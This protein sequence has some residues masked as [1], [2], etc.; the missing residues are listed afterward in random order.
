MP[1]QGGQTVEYDYRAIKH[2]VNDLHHWDAR[3]EDWFHATGRQPIRVIYEEFV[4]SRAVT[5]GRV[6]DDLGVDPRQLDGRKGPV[7]RQSDNLS[8]DWVS[9]FREDDAE[10]QLT[11]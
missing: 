9:R 4:H 1:A 3:W 6:L 8:Q 11:S 5:L 10:Y 7:I 2:L